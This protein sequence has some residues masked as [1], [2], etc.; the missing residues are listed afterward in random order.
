MQAHRPR[1]AVRAARLAGI[2]GLSAL[3]AGCA[4]GGGPSLLSQPQTGTAEATG[5]ATALPK[6]TGTVPARAQPRETLAELT[7]RNAENPKDATAAL[8]YARHLKA[9]GK[10][11]DAL[12]VLDKAAD[13][14]AANPAFLAEHGLLALQHGDARRAQEL[15]QKAGPETTR[16]WRVPSGLGVALATLGRQDEAQKHFKRALAL[17]PNNPIVLN[18]LAMSHILARR[19]DTAEALLKTAKGAGSEREHL[20]QNL[21]LAMALKGQPGGAAEDR[22]APL[23]AAPRKPAAVEPQAVLAQPASSP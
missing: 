11:R 5:A 7:Q 2:A 8:R 22:S 20:A 13:A 10:S 1:P 17:S 16:D 6:T 15:L 4:A 9:A 12:A 19:I 23:P 21:T 3:L 18:N 14:G